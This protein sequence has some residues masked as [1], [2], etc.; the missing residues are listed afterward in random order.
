MMTK[1]SMEKKKK[2]KGKKRRG[3]EGKEDKNNISTF[4]ILI[5]TCSSFF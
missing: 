1:L 2:R 5:Y 4:E 3:E